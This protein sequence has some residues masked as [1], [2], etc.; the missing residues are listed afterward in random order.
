MAWVIRSEASVAC[1]SL[2][3]TI[4]SNCS[5]NLFS[6]F[7]SFFFVFVFV[8]FIFYFILESIEK[9]PGCTIKLNKVNSSVRLHL[10]SILQVPPP[11]CFLRR[12]LICNCFKFEMAFPPSALITIVFCFCFFLKQFHFRLMR[13]KKMSS[14]FGTRQSSLYVVGNSTKTVNEEMG[15]YLLQQG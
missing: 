11:K 10:I 12:N 1:F 13:Q 9:Y 14:E 7:S 15:H 8:Y 3:K 4:P 5:K 6:L 2:W